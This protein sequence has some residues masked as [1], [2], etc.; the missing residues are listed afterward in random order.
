MHLLGGGVLRQ[1]IIRQER[2][3]YKTLLVRKNR[4]MRLWELVIFLIAFLAIISLYEQRSPAFIISTILVAIITLGGTPYIYQQ[5]K[6]P[7]YVLTS[8][9]L[10]IYL[11]RR[12]ERYPLIQIE[13]TYDLP[14]FFRLNGKKRPLLVSNAFLEDLS[15]ELSRIERQNKKKKR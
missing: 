7:R 6:H 5:F 15:D 9:E 1:S 11:G 14:H 2:A 13:R 8:A 4:E 3:S 10:I 12:E